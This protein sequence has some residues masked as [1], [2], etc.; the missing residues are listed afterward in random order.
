MGEH[1]E[2]KDVLPQ[3]I[4]TSTA[5]RA[6]ETANVFLSQCCG[7]VTFIAL[8]SLYMAEPP[9]ILDALKAIPEHVT[10]VMVI[11][12]NPGLETVL[13]LLTGKVES[14][15]TASVAYLELPIDSWSAVSFDSPVEKWE[16]WKPKDD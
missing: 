10:R 15:P 16:K 2:E 8:D 1:L 12:H 4:L 9:V 11:G 3:V 13:Q 7:E 5:R 14:L 6:R